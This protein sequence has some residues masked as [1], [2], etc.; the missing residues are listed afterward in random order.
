MKQLLTVCAVLLL[1]G[2]QAQN[3]VSVSNGPGVSTS[4]VG[5]I[6]PVI[7]QFMPLQEDSWFWDDLL[8]EWVL[9]IKYDYT[10]SP[11]GKLVQV[12]FSEADNTLIGEQLY[13]YDAQ[14]RLDTLTNRYFDPSF[15]Q[16][17]DDYRNIYTYDEWSNVIFESLEIF[18]GSTWEVVISANIEFEYVSNGLFTSK[19]RTNLL[20]GNIQ[21]IDLTLQEF[22]A[23]LRLTQRELQTYFDENTGFVPTLKYELMYE[24]AN[25]APSQFTEYYFEPFATEWLPSIRSTELSFH[26]YNSFDDYATTNRVNQSFNGTIW[27]NISKSETTYDGLNSVELISIFVSGFW[28][29]EYRISKTFESNGLPSLLLE[30]F[31][32]EGEWQTELAQEYIIEYDGPDNKISRMIRKEW[33]DKFQSNQNAQ[34]RDFFYMPTS[35]NSHKQT[36][37]SQVYPNPASEE[38]NINIA[39]ASAH[40]EFTYSLFD[41]TGK[42]YLNGKLKGNHSTLKFDSLQD[43]YYFLQLQGKNGFSKCDKILIQRAK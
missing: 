26:I 38:I 15:N 28:L 14:E 23:N 5:I 2:L 21:S 1:L 18:N 29:P 43:G 32:F 35:M 39:H 25:T 4:A 12:V 34:R 42:R 3:D 11:Q 24:G 31:R 13:S 8:Q 7:N 16:M 37:Y 40:D 10:Y 36:M 41:I 30:E 22:D 9:A 27:E 17:I 6:D 19:T 33:D 20:D